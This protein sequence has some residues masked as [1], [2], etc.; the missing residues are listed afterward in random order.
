ME[1][2][3]IK[4]NRKTV[5]IQ[6]NSDMSVTLRVPRQATH[7]TR[8]MNVEP[9]FSTVIHNALIKKVDVK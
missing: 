6:V 4:S 7:L 3:V 8:I 2:T 5:A 9:V 1:D